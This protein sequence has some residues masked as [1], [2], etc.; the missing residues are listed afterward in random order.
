MP[1]FLRFMKDQFGSDNRIGVF[2]GDDILLDAEIVD[3]ANGRYFASEL[4]AN[5]V[6]KAYVPGIAGVDI[7]IPVIINFRP[8]SKIQLAITGTDSDNL[9][10]AED[11]TS[12]YI[13]L[14][15]ASG[16]TTIETEEQPLRITSRG[17][18]QS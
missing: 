3:Y 10:L 12:V 14:S 1:K 11:G 16:E 6:L 5:D 7:E 9:L 18:R 15:N 13:I 17:T 4:G 8:T 2:R